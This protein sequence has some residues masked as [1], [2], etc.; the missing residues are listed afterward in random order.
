MQTVLLF[1]YYKTQVSVFCYAGV[2][3]RRYTCTKWYKSEGCI[4]YYVVSVNTGLLR[5]HVPAIDTS[6]QCVV[7]LQCCYHHGIV[8]RKVPGSIHVHVTGKIPS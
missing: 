1:Y 7:C 2:H 4:N 8:H 6:A 3:V 5:V